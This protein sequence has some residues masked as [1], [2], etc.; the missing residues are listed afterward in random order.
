M[1]LKPT[2]LTSSSIPAQSSC[3]R[4]GGGRHKI[5]AS[6]GGSGSSGGGAADNERK[7]FFHFHRNHAKFESPLLR[8]L[9]S[10]IK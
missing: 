5:N 4:R 3:Q 8:S 1:K 9:Q 10:L 7:V 2:G 6:K